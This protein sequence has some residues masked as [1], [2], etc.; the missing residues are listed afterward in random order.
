MRKRSGILAVL[1]AL[2]A[3]M[4]AE[5]TAAQERRM[6]R[7]VTVAATGTARAEPDRALFT[8]GV[9]SEG[10]T[11]REAL[12]RNT[13][14]MRKVIDGLKAAGVAAGDMQTQHL[15]VDPRYQPAGDGKLPRIVG[16]RASNSIRVTIRDLAKLGSLIDQATALGANQAGQIAFEVSEAEVLRDQARRQAMA[17]ALRR[18]KLFAEAG[19][20]SVG[21]VLQ[22][23]EEAGGGMRPP[24]PQARAMA[25]DAVPIERGTQQLEARVVVTYALQ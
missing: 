2:A 15:Q 10:D 3:G 17:N 5:T 21:P 25:A 22:I 18:A 11:A 4:A 16:Y 14:V 19:G 8:T 13:E 23:S 20:A 1:L 9:V 12:A 24:M 6:E 7:T